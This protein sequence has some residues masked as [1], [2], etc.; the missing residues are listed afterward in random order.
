MNPQDKKLA[1]AYSSDIILNHHLRQKLK[2]IRI[3]KFNHLTNILTLSLTC[4]LKLFLNFLID[5][6]QY[7]EYLIEKCPIRLYL[8][9]IYW[10]YLCY[11]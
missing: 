1:L 9:L 3:G 10:F 8:Y 6:A 4:E 11:I 5:E 7:L 2:L